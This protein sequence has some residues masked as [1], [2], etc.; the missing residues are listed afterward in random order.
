MNVMT[1]QNGT[2]V[3]S[4]SQT[5]IDGFTGSPLAA[6]AKG[7]SWQWS[8]KTVRVDGATGFGAVNDTSSEKLRRNAAASARK[9]VGRA[10]VQEGVRTP[11]L[12]EDVALDQSFTIT[13]GSQSWVATLIDM[14][15]IARPL[16][17]FVGAMPPKGQPLLVSREIEAP[18]R[19]SYLRQDQEGVVCFTP[20][21]RMET[22]DGP[23]LVEE[24]VA[25]DRVVTKD[26]GVEEILWVGDRHV[27]GARLH[28]MPDL[29]P[30]RIREGAID[31]GRPNGD[32][33][34]S[35]DHRMLIRGAAA[36][37]LWGEHEVLVAARDLIDDARVTRD[38]SAKSV[39]YIHLMLPS[40][41][42]LIANGL[43]TESFHPDA[44]HLESVDE[45][46]LL[47]MFDVMPFL[48][49]DT[50]AYG[51]MSRRVLRQAEAAL[52]TRSR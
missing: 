7:S 38:L 35:P 45:Q 13:D 46:Q 28:A 23:Q 19:L 33:I 3:I 41:N 43:E 37:A 32:L 42:I 30:V 24:L 8:G 49:D 39:T 20:G 26:N 4:W 27:S 29:R 36:M 10:L 1:G 18:A 9:L 21:T 34:V 11:F 14:P 31:E 51:P 52:I 15:E 2:Y 16:L 17:M 50:S 40:H 22:P 44:V 47:R 25:G 5:E 12:E 6:L 48:R